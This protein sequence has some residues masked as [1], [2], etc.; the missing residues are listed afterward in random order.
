MINMSDQYGLTLRTKI[1]QLQMNH[2]QKRLFVD[3]FTTN[4]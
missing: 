1:E 4:N 3:L 2:H